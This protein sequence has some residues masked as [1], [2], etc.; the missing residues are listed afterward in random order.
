MTSLSELRKAACV[1]YDCTGKTVVQIPLEMWERYVAERL[2]A[3]GKTLP[4]ADK[5][6]ASIQARIK[7]AEEA[8]RLH[9]VEME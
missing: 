6:R 8:A 2:M 7:E 9:K 1:S 5:L 4:T 3:N